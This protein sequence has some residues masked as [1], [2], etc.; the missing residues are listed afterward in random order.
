MT[1]PGL[2]WQRCESEGLQCPQEV[3]P[4]S[5]TSNRTTKLC[6][7]RAQHRLGRVRWNYRK[8]PG[9]RFA[10]SGS[11]EYQHHSTSK[12]SATRF[13]IVD[14]RQDVVVHWRDA[15]SWIVPP[16]AVACDLL[17]GGQG[18]SF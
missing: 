10:T 16:V 6:R 15:K 5:F 1:R 14:E 12:G 18:W 13:G 8:S 3:S 11:P 7:H 2:H 4:N 17:G 9:W